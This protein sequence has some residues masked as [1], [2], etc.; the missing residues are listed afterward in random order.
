[1]KATP[2]NT[3]LGSGSHPTCAADERGAVMVLGL[4]L[5]LAA[6]CALWCLIGIGDA[7]IARDATQEAT[8]SAA[9]TNAVVHARGMNVIAFINMV[10]FAFVMVYLTLSWLD[11]LV[12]TL[13][14]ITGVQWGPNNCVFRYASDAVDDIPVPWCNIAGSLTKISK[15]L[16]K[17]DKGVFDRFAKLAPPLFETQVWVAQ[18]TPWLGSVSAADMAGEYHRAA[19]SMSAANF[20]GGGAIHPLNKVVLLDRIKAFENTPMVRGSD[21]KLKPDDKKSSTNLLQDRRI[22]LP[23]ESEAANQFCVKAVRFPLDYVRDA[24]MSLGASSWGAKQLAKEPLAT[25]VTTETQAIAEVNKALLCNAKDEAIPALL[26]SALDLVKKGRKGDAAR[27]EAVKTMLVSGSNLGLKMVFDLGLEQF[28]PPHVNK[29]FYLDSNYLWKMNWPD[30]MAR[31][32]SRFDDG[33]VAGPKK[34]V[35]YASNGSDWMQIWAIAL[36]SP[37]KATAADAIVSIPSQLFGGKPKAVDPGGPE[38]FISQAEYYYDCPASW[39]S[40]QCNKS[41]MATYQLKWKARLRRIHQPDVVADMGELLINNLLT[42]PAFGDKFKA[43]MSKVIKNSIARDSISS[44]LKSLITKL[45]LKKVKDSREDGSS[46][47]LLH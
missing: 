25:I 9:F 35:A 16:L 12:S 47:E 39:G 13:L 1:M 44:S 42:S 10:L 32:G 34:V 14:L 20:P 17:F 5:A 46:H 45:S 11:I 18:I 43:L 37:P 29:K 31:Q 33:F 28:L 30:P 27:Q 21:G 40:T 4:F 24:V 36:V 38:A 6:V 26:A 2:E 7:I 41:A 19:F 22:G 8:D 23:V 15:N 3:E